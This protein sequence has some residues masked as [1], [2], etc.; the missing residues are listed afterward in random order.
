MIIKL[1]EVD[2]LNFSGK[3]VGITSG[4]F[5]LFHYYHLH[6]LER[7]KSE[8]DILIVGVDCDSLVF[9]NKAKVPQIPEYQRASIINALECTD[10]VFINRNLEHFTKFVSRSNKMFKNSSTI[11]GT[12]AIK[13]EGVEL[14]IIQDV[15]DI[16]STSKL[17]E[18]IRKV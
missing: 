4:C 3:V 6:Y 10:V 2:N 1:E 5:D 13:V 17:I 7:C 11:Y 12:E 14:V 15:E 8:C 18:K 16:T 9:K